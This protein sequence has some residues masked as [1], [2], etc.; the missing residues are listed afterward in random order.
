[1][2]KKNLNI[3]IRKMEPKDSLAVYI[4]HRGTLRAIN[5]KDYPKEII[6]FWVNG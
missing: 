6:D 2:S 5:S 4:L 1:M 3:Q